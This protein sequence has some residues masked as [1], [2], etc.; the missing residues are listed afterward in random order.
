MRCHDAAMSADA[1]NRLHRH[2]P[3]A[4]V[5][6]L[7]A[8]VGA[9]LWPA[10][11]LGP[12]DRHLA[13]AVPLL[14]VA[15]AGPRR[16]TGAAWSAGWR[17]S[18]LGALAMRGAGCTWNDI[19]DR[20]I[21]AQVERTRGRPLPVGRGQAARRADL[22]G[23]AVAGRRG[24]PVQ[25]Q[26]VRGRRGARLAGPGRD[27]SDHEAPHLLAAGRAG[28]RLQ[29][30][31]AGGLRRGHR[32]ALL[33]DGRALCR[34][35]RLDAGLRHDLRHA[36]PAR[37]CRSSAC[38]RPRAAS[39]TRRGAGSRCSPVLALLAWALGRLSRAASVP[40]TSPAC[41]RSRCTSPGRSPSCKPRRP[42]RLPRQVQGQR[43]GRLAAA[44]RHHRR[45]TCICR[46]RACR[47]IPKA[48]SA[49]TPPSK[50]PA[51]VPEFKL[52]LATEYVPIWQATE[53][54]LEE[55]NVDPPYWAFCWPGGQAIAR[56]LLDNPEHGARQ[57]RDRLRRRLGRVLDG[58]GARRRRVGDRQRHR[59][60]VAGRRPSQRRGQ[61]PCASTSA[62]R[63]GWPGPTARPTADV[64]IA[65]DVCYEREMSVA[66]AGLAARPC[67]GW[68][69][70]CCWATPAA[71]I[72]APRGSK[73]CARYDIPTSLQ[74]ENRGMRET[75]VWRVLPH[76]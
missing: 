22:D 49:P 76:P 30:G 37:R 35:R 16:R 67:H 54:W 73:N 19:V 59:C 50:R 53:A 8:A 48:S 58:G 29:L 12:A 71:T 36:G 10:V 57:A 75:V 44:G 5:A 24:H 17:C 45:R 4:L 56:Y 41:W 72:S 46:W 27:L 61:R 13:A 9:A 63:T 25:A 70:W 33:G 52:W 26:Q 40:S 28:P 47:P 14:V 1:D 21:D 18:P 74:L 64:V 43:A 31:R 60:A 23:A 66:G 32:H 6:A 11:A 34:R 20:K 68:A 65:G 42:G 69:D 38:A 62:P 55:Q 3:P 7:P 51:M 15:G 39:P 2:R